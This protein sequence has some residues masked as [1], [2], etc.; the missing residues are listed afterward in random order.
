MNPRR[1]GESSL[2]EAMNSKSE[3]AL[4]DLGFSPGA[5]EETDESSS[6]EVA[7]GRISK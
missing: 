1:V 2:E 6:R 4:R 7:C 5:P 3:L